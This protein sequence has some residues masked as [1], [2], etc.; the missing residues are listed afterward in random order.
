MEVHGFVFSSL[1][2][3]DDF[4]VGQSTKLHQNSTA[5]NQRAAKSSKANT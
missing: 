5:F 2:N 1:Q 3:G 4:V